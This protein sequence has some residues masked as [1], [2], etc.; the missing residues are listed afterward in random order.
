MELLGHYTSGTDG[1]GNA[2]HIAGAQCASVDAALRTGGTHLPA[3]QTVS[4]INEVAR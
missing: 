2:A 4:V 1:A 3:D